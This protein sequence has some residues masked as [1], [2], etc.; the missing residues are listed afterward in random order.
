MTN[1]KKSIFIADCSYGFAMKTAL[2][3]KENGWQVYAGARYDKDVKFLRENGIEGLLMD[4]RS[5]ESVRSVAREAIK[6][7]GEGISGIVM[8]AG[9]TQVGA[10]EDAT[11]ESMREE[12]D[13]MVFGP[14]EAIASF[15]PNFRKNNYGRIVF[16]N[17]LNGR[18]TFP[19]MGTYGSARRAFE[20]FCDATRRELMDTPIKVSCIVPYCL[21]QGTD[22]PAKIV[23]SDIS[24]DRN[25]FKDFYKKLADLSDHIM[26]KNTTDR[27]TRLASRE[28]LKALESPNPK[29]RV[30]IGWDAKLR[31]MAHTL[32]P[33]K[34]LDLM[35]CMKTRQIYK[36]K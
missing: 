7:S 32:L 33:A 31:D 15:I 29:T 24:P 1:G 14:I 16:V 13:N 2:F 25:G 35:L 30:V 18:L 34:M 26:D 12:F 17:N 9:L 19:F 8:Y 22:D 21:K 5:S 20:S 6:R 11:R 23:A 4:L 36:G 3:L 10:V 28:I 27:F